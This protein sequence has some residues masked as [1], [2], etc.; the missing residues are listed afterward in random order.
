[1]AA[2]HVGI[3]RVP[4]VHCTLCGEDLSESI[5]MNCLCSSTWCWK[6]RLAEED[7]PLL[8]ARIGTHEI[9]LEGV[10]QL[11]SVSAW[12]DG[13]SAQ[14]EGASASTKAKPLTFGDFYTLK[15]KIGKGSTARVYLCT[16][17]QDSG[18]ELYAVKIINK[19]KVTASYP[20]LMKQ[21]KEEA[22]L[23]EELHHP[24]IIALHAMFESSC[25]LHLVTEYAS[26]GELFEYLI[27]R[28]NGLLSE[29]E[30]SRLIRQ[31][32]AA[33]AYMHE[34]GVM[35][36][37]IK[38]ENILL[39]EKPK[40]SKT[41]LKLIDF[42]LAKSTRDC[43]HAKTFFGTVG[44][45]APEMLTKKYTN[46]IDLWAAGVL[47][48]ILLCGVFPFEDDVRKR[49]KVDYT[50]RFP[51]WTKSKLS[52]SAKDLLSSLLC[53]YPSQRSTAQSALEHP[54]IRGSTASPKCI[55]SSPRQLKLRARSNQNTILVQTLGSD[56]FSLDNVTPS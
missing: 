5:A 45:I 18:D 41:T 30:A 53:V 14:P 20:T 3:K 48:Y 11:D 50:L 49:L 17:P 12:N 39:A 22:R 19:Q 46:A 23:L 34:C 42:G 55:L 44:Y 47:T 8:E 56:G 25:T 9:N 38:L 37:D 15:S 36:R 43:E 4:I 52:A 10:H 54:W 51:P 6:T 7:E 31:I 1:M 13:E 28:P 2:W 29:A 32:L 33:I 40:G 21:L 24:N 16:S 27:S 26:G 35:H